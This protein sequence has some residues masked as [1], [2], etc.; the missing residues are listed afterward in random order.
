MLFNFF[1]MFLKILP[2]KEIL[3]YLHLTA[4]ELRLL[5]EFKQLDPSLISWQEARIETRSI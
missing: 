5:H 1:Y 3:R 2:F 4:A